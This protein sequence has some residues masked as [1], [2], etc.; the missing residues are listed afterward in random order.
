MSL[1]RIE[2]VHT[3][4]LYMGASVTKFAVAIMN[5]TLPSPVVE[6]GDDIL[7]LEFVVGN[8]SS[9]TQPIEPVVKQAVKLCRPFH[10]YR[11]TFARLLLLP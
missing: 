11:I 2:H 10:H 8:D 7:N 6:F 3:K 5:Y 1:W 4:Y 9:S